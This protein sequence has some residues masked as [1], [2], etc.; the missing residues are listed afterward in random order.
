VVVIDDH[1]VVRAG[2]VALLSRQPGLRV[3]GEGGTGDSVVPIVQRTSPDLVIM[4]VQ[5]PGLDSHEVV[6]QLRRRSPD[7]GII[8]LTM[9]DGALVRRTHLEAG[10]SAVISK[11]AGT[12]DLVAAIRRVAQQP[13]TSGP[14]T[15]REHEI[16]SLMA[17][18]L[19]N[20]EIGSLL[21]IATGTVKRHSS[22]LFAKLGASS[23]TQAVA[24]AR[25]VGLLL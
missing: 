12:A 17:D 14:L 21:K 9:H 24:L 25:R 11:G 8:L 2:L 10:A 16:L 22:Q 7:L 6:R 13:E 5:M 3:V 19:S 23:R 1:E 4:D 15:A 18:G 20:R